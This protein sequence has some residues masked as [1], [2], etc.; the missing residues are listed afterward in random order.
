[1]SRRN[2]LLWIKKTMVCCGALSLLAG[3]CLSKVDPSL[4][5][6]LAVLSGSI[7]LVEKAVPMPPEEKRKISA[8]RVAQIYNLKK[9]NW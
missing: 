5:M 9:S 3:A 7:L 8:N 6:F 1:M 4:A 2:V